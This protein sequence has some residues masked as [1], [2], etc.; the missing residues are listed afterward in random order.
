VGIDIHG[1]IEVRPWASWPDL[2][3]EIPWKAAA[4]LDCLNITRDYDAFGCLF[5]VMNFAGFQPIAADRGLPEDAGEL[6]R[7]E[8]QALYQPAQWTTWIS[9]EEI[10]SIDWREPAER[11]DARLHEY[12]RTP[13]GQWQCV[14]KAAWSR[15]M[16][17]AQGLEVP[18]PGTPP[19]TWPEGSIWTSGDMQ[20][21][22]ERLTRGHAVP[23]DSAWQPVWDVMG[24]LGRLHGERNCR[25]IVWFDG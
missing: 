7:Q 16:R 14:G 13:D 3:S 25:L 4:R 11:V 10:R 24:V 19:G 8:R 20:W 17:Q 1:F 9:W 12:H 22:A 18:P 21:R 15:E 23:A 2:P 6:V 5:G